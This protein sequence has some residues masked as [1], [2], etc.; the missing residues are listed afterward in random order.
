MADS[1]DQDED[2][3][4][5]QMAGPVSVVQPIVSVRQPIVS[6]A[7]NVKLRSRSLQGGS[8]G[9]RQTSE[10]AAPSGRND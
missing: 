3:P 1:E 10:E 5:Q 7:A 4:N 8:F 6:N 9:S 2:S